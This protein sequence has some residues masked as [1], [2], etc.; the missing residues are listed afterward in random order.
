MHLPGLG[1]GSEVVLGRWSNASNLRYALRARQGHLADREGSLSAL[2]HLPATLL[3]AG[4]SA[5]EPWGKRLPRDI[6][7]VA[8]VPKLQSE[9]VDS[10]TG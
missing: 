4:W 5:W 6:T 9:G 3:Q 8:E 1:P 10:L 7:W 2:A